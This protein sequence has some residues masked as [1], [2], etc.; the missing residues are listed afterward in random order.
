MAAGPKW[1]RGGANVTGVRR[2]AQ[3]NGCG[4]YYGYRGPP[5]TKKPRE[6]VCVCSPL[7][8]GKGGSAAPRAGLH[9]G[10]RSNPYIATLPK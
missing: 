3:G 5:V 2:G 4:G 10:N 6:R 7:Q 1:A 8:R 9:P